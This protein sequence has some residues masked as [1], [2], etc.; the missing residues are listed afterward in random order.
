MLSPRLRWLGCHRE[1]I[2]TV[3]DLRYPA[4]RYRLSPRRGNAMA[5]PLFQVDAFTDTAFAGNPAAVCLLDAPADARWMQQ[6]ATE[7]NLSE[8]AFVRPLAEGWELR[9][10]TPAV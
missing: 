3:P 2:A 5:L 10:F 1:R 7:M 4:S 8:T 6:V 9:W